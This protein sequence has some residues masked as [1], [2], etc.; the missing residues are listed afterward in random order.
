[1]AKKS[2][3]IAKRN[4][5]EAL[6]TA[7]GVLTQACNIRDTPRSQYYYWCK[8]DPEFKKAADEVQEIVL[9]FAESALYKQIKSGGRGA[10]TATIFLLKTKGKK[11][12]YIEKTELEHSGEIKGAPQIGFGDTVTRTDDLMEELEEEEPDDIF[13]DEDNEDED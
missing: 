9:D 10:V 3:E 6:E 5:L 8:N 7:L 2:T 12:G 4:F 1:M 13:D 11:R